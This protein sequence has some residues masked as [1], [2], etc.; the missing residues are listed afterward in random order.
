LL[1]PATKI[2][3][4]ANE[5]DASAGL[6]GPHQFLAQRKSQ[7]VIP[8]VPYPARPALQTKSFVCHVNQYCNGWVG[9]CAHTRTRNPHPLRPQNH[10]LPINPDVPNLPNDRTET[11]HDD[12]WI[13]GDKIK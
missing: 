12:G 13:I 2:A 8:M 6:I 7:K 1:S 5:A 3:P 4:N 10:R 9:P 11:G